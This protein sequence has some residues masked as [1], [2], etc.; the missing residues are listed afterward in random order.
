MPPPFGLVMNGISSKAAGGINNNYKYNGKE[1]QNGEFSDR[2]GLEEYDYG[3]RFYDAQI[4]RWGVIDGKS[5]VYYS[6]SPFNYVGNSPTNAIDIDGNLFIFANG[7]MPDQWMNGGGNGNGPVR[8]VHNYPSFTK[9]ADYEPDRG[10][11]KDGPHNNGIAFSYW[12]GINT[13]Y[14]DKYDDH[15]AYYTNGSFTPLATASTRFDE[16][17]QAGADLINKLD[18]GEITLGTG[19][20][21]KMVGHSQGA[22][23][24]A[25]IAS[26]LANSKYGGL[27]EFVDYLSP[28]QPGDFKHPKKIKGRQFST[29]SDQVSSKGFIAWFFGNSKY[30]K[31]DGAEWG[32]EREKYDGGM[33]G[34]YVDTWLND[35]I[36]Y[37]KGL[38]I[39]VNVIK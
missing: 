8:E 13:A 9:N 27:M 2:S 29:K 1:L 32:V 26:A 10:F 23:Y 12:E 7:F 38:G 4:G 20:T 19:E 16:G 3:A 37:W 22:A 24:V 30:E 15:E 21:I 25:G 17:K 18:A 6:L 33:G 36:T 28:H 11:F 34:H 31:M 35:L 14:M 5:E 39:K